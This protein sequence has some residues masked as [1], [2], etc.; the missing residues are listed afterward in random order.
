MDKQQQ[1]DL[2]ELNTSIKEIEDHYQAE[3]DEADWYNNNMP[4]VGI[5]IAYKSH[6]PEPPGLTRLKRLRDNLVNSNQSNNIQ[7][8]PTVNSE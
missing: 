8:P 1:I 7:I 6:P 4:D 2:T 5:T 3:K